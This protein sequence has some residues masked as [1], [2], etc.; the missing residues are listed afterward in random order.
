[1]PIREHPRHRR[2]QENLRDSVIMRI[3]DRVLL[4]NLERNYSPLPIVAFGTNLLPKATKASY[5][6]ALR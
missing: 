6:G 3:L 4:S 1:V 5:A 2:R